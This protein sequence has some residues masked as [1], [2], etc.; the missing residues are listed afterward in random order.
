MPAARCKSEPHQKLEG[1]ERKDRALQI[2][3]RA[4]PFGE[5]R[6]VLAAHGRLLRPSSEW[7][8]TNPSSASK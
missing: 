2:Q 5:Q 6:L 3:S 4:R 1:F 8:A 7:M